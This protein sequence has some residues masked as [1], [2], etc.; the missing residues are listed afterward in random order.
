MDVILPLES[1]VILHSNNSMCMLRH[2]AL[3]VIGKGHH[4][5]SQRLELP[6]S[7]GVPRAKG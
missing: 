6:H 3:T 1:C 2:H 4:Q 7:G 5:R